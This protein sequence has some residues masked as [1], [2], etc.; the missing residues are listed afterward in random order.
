[1]P[2]RAAAGARWRAWWRDRER[3]DVNISA[4]I[5]WPL[6]LGIIWL[7]LQVGCYFY[8]RQV[9]LSAAQQ[10]ASVARTQP[11]SIDRATAAAER[12]VT[13]TAGGF[14][15]DPQIT[16]TV[17]GPNV[18]VVVTAAAVSLVPGIRFTVHQESLQ[19]IEQITP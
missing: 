7:A 12:F 19:P 17:E 8:G 2:H 6:M 14:V 1:M 11:V 16:A 10:G 5:L 9:A 4:V 13:A 3:G 18:R 15:S